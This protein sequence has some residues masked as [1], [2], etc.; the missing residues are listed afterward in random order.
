M[1]RLKQCKGEDKKLYNFASLNSTM[2]RLKLVSFLAK[3]KELE[4]KS[5]FH[6]GSIKTLLAISNHNPENWGL[7]S[8]MVRLKQYSRR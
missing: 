6:Y 2:V 5:Q 3:C 1:V 7:N 4:G 8:T